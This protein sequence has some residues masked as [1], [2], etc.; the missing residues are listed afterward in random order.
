MSLYAKLRLAEWGRYSRDESL[1]FP[2]C[3]AF[4]ANGGQSRDYLCGLP[5]H[6]ALVDVIVRQM[7]ILLRQV[8]IVHYSQTGSARDKALRIECVWSTYGRRLKQGQDHVGIELDLAESCGLGQS[9][10]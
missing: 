4:A 2:G 7:D 3:S 1:G 10:A 6:V 9:M 5:T 8:I